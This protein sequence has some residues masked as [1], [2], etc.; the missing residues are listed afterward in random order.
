MPDSHHS[1]ALE[2]LA[3]EE[4]QTQVADRKGLKSIK[5]YL[6]SQM[7]LTEDELGQVLKRGKIEDNDDSSD[8]EEVTVLPQSHAMRK[9]S[10]LHLIANGKLSEILEG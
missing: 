9:R 2:F 7:G 8:S 1:G 4:V 3:K 5:S 10:V 6:T